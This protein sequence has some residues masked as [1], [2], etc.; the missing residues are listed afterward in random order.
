MTT[1]FSNNDNNDTKI[2]LKMDLLGVYS[3]PHLPIRA[4]AGKQGQVTRVEYQV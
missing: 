4:A 1:L 2:I 3:S